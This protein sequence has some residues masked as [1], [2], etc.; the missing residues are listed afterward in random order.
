MKDINVFEEIL[1]RGAQYKLRGV[2]QCHNNHFTC[3]VKDHNTCIWTYFDDLS[4]NLQGFSNFRSKQVYREGWFFT[5]YELWEMPIQCERNDC[6]NHVPTTCA[7]GNLNNE[8]KI[9]ESAYFSAA[10]VVHSDKKRRT[11]R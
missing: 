1:I 8:T 7:N 9:S 5:I 2:V 3:A 10:K 6:M 4:V 11:K